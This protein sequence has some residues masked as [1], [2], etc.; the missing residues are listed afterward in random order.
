MAKVHPHL[1]IDG[2][3]VPPSAATLAAVVSPCTEEVAGRVAVAGSSD[4]EA[5]VDAARRAFDGG[6]WTHMAPEDRAAVL[7]RLAAGIRDRTDL[8]AD[9][10]SAEVGSVRRWAPLGQVGVA[11]AVFDAYAQ[12]AAT[13][14]WTDR[15]PGSTGGTARVDRLPVGVVA[16]IVPWNA[17]LFTA[18]LKLAPALL[19]GATVVL[20]PAVQTAMSTAVLAEVAMD[21]E[22][23]AGVL[24]IV[25]ADTDAAELL[26]RHRAVDKV[27]FTGSTAVGRRIGALC[28]GDIRRC[29]LELGGKSAAIVLEDLPLDDRTA[30]KLLSGVTVNNGQVCAA[31][32]RLLVPERRAAEVI[33][34]LAAQ[35]AA[36]RIGDPFD[37]ATDIG[38]LGTEAQRT[39]V[40]EAVRRARDDG[41]RIVVGGSRPTH[42]ARGWFVEPTVVADVEPGMQVAQTEIFGPVL[43]VL[44]YRD[45]DHAV[46]LANDSEFGLA[47]AVWSADV[48][49]AEAVASRLHTGVVA[50]NSAAP[51]D[52]H[53]PFGGFKRSGVGREA[54]PEGIDPYTELRT[55]MLPR[56]RTV[57]RQAQ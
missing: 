20:K 38:P 27:S 36:L 17:P 42:P 21:A 2:Q 44:T 32:S 57:D 24:N 45:E 37:D 31:L 39:R 40:E 19:A 33:D 7:R 3:F 34:A 46:A 47:G 18:A 13:Y 10:I 8:L 15:R 9:L 26:V 25:P 28:G 16:A 52:L 11:A 43:C 48:A 4:I 5:A 53:A 35:A 50:I 29:T 55:I 1:F 12:W 56:Q 22:L 54:G 49:H 30:A 41:A 6:R 51:L 14:P 23:P